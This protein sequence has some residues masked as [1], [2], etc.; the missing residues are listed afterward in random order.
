MEK[1]L[2][3]IE[4]S[5][6]H[7]S[8]KSQDRLISAFLDEFEELLRIMAQGKHRFVIDSVLGK[9]IIEETGESFIPV[10][11]SDIKDTKLRGRVSRLKSPWLCMWIL[12][13]ALLQVKIFVCIRK[14]TDIY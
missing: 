13:P 4:P 11:I 1:D 8:D 3:Y 9:R 2:F 10:R 14:R 6:I 7:F 12:V 5:A